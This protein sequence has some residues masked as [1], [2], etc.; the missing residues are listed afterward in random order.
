MAFQGNHEQQWEWH[1]PLTTNRGGKFLTSMK[2]IALHDKVIAQRLQSGPSNATYLSAEIQN[3][4]IGILA[5]IVR[6]DIRND[7]KGTPYLA[8]LADET[9]DASKKEQLAIV[10]RYL[11]NCV[12][13][14]R[15]IKFIHAKEL[16]APSL[17]AYIMDVAQDM[18]IDKQKVVGQ[19]YDGASVMSGVNAGVQALVR[20]ECPY[21][22]YIHCYA[23]R[24]NLVLCDACKVVVIAEDVLCQLQELYVF[25]SGSVPNAIFS[26][27]SNVT[28]KKLSETRWSS[29]YESV[30]A[31]K[32]TYCDIIKTLEDCGNHADST[33]SSKAKGLLAQVK[34]F[35]FIVG[36]CILEKVFQRVNIASKALQ[37]PGLDVCGAV[38]TIKNTRE[39]LEALKEQ[40]AWNAIYSDA[41]KLA[42]DAVV[43][44]T[45]PPNRRHRSVPRWLEEHYFSIGPRAQAQVIN[46]SQDYQ[47][48]LLLPIVESMIKEIDQRFSDSS[49]DVF[50]GALSFSPLSSSF[51]CSEKLFSMGLHYDLCSETD[52]S[53]DLAEECLHA[54]KVIKEKQDHSSGTLEM[55]IDVL[56]ALSSLHSTYSTL[57]KLC[58][59][60][61]TLPVSSATCERMMSCLKR[62]KSYLRCSMGDDRLSDLCLLST[63]TYTINLDE[64]VTKFAQNHNNCRIRL[65]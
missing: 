45:P 18:G 23:H 56:S 2:L 26:S 58:Q 50:D 5:S 19:C 64:F 52:G 60:A 42:T 36:L 30:K 22:L 48:E 21:A 39:R 34:S 28:I 46:P 25:M 16:N 24:L 54:Q 65:N 8:I 47:N 35:E 41:V 62:V 55:S 10:V 57:L 1:D 40:A 6:D 59:I 12:P 43:P 27:S 44:V 9:K 14:E 53:S 49:T 33:R 61:V 38:S 31:V 29:R 15:F 7:I 11:K 17:K 37:D 13:V 51:L 32:L 63:D 3:E 4:V 20:Q